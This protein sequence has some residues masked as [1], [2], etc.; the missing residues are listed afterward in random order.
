MVGISHVGWL[1]GLLVAQMHSWLFYM[2]AVFMQ[3][4]VNMRKRINACNSLLTLVGLA[5]LCLPQHGFERFS[6]KVLGNLGNDQGI[7][8]PCVFQCAVN[9]SVRCKLLGSFGCC[10]NVNSPSDFKIE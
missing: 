2:L 10:V 3:Q 6:M 1:V 5:N 9:A 4:P 8:R 7:S